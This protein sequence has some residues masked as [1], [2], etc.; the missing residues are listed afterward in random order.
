[1]VN[2]E[3]W[4]GREGKGKSEIIFYLFPASEH[5][6]RKKKKKNREESETGERARVN[7]ERGEANL[8]FF[9]REGERERG[10]GEHTRHAKHQ[11]P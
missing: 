8:T 1:M 3:A 5:E 11:I 4:R 2:R 6:E 10:R 7:D 9:K